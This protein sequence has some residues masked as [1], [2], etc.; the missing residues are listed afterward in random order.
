MYSRPALT[1]ILKILTAAGGDFKLMAALVYLML[2][3]PGTHDK[4]K[5]YLEK[6]A[7]LCAT[8]ADAIEEIL[9]S[10]LAQDLPL[11]GSLWATHGTIQDLKKR[12][13]V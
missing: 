8:D 1:N 5:E 7:E 9:G 6:W 3:N 2:E 10:G 13:A 11:M 4:A 12:K